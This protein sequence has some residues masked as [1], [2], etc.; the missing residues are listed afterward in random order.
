MEVAH[1]KQDIAGNLAAV[2]A[3]MAL[4]D[5]GNG[6]RHSGTGDRTVQVFGIFGAGGSVTVEGTL[7]GTH[8]AALADTE[9]NTLTFT[10]A[11]IKTILQNVLDIRPVVSTGDGTT[12][13]T[14]IINVRR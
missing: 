10:G 13:I 12:S 7:D 5:V 11:G 2:W 6:L 3:D 8:W 9:G 1:S 4:G 14:T